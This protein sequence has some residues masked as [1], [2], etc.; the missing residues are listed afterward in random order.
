[1][2]TESKE[3]AKFLP[4]IFKIWI[5]TQCLGNHVDCKKKKDEWISKKI[6]LDI[7]H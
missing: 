5:S 6:K 7:Q 3:V 1:M 2:K 4:I